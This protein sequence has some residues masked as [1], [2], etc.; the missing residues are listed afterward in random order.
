MNTLSG[1][2]AARIG[3]MILAATLAAC[4]R[5]S[6]VIANAPTYFGSYRQAAALQYGQDPR[7]MLDVYSPEDAAKHPV[8][9]FFYGGSWTAGE[10]S[11]YRFVGAALAARGFVAVLPDYRLYPA[12][13]FPRFVE[14]GAKAVAWVQIHASEFGGDPD[15]LVLMGHSAGAH[16]AAFLALN[17]T[18]LAKAGVRP[19]SIVGLV[20]LS[21]PYALDSN[22]DTLRATFGKPYTPADWQPVQF[23]SDRSPP[24][25]LLHGLADTVVHPAHAEKLRDALMAHKVHVETHL[26]P[27]RDHT[28]TIASF[29]L[30][31]RRRTSSLDETIKF[32]RSVTS[33]SGQSH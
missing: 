19:G 12:V 32:L 2:A 15:R 16:M 4:S 3:A 11:D 1:G 28:D 27:D 20:G 26:Y 7:Q 18:Y 9:I 31:K 6:F 14:D 5:A 13:K 21:G 8:V 22:S 25:L 10:R 30:A 24:T 17:D 33:Q 23:A 29:S